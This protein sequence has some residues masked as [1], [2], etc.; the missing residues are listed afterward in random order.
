M[1][2][3]VLTISRDVKWSGSDFRHEGVDAAFGHRIVRGSK[4]LHWDG[5]QALFV[6]CDQ[7]DTCVAAVAVRPF[8]S[9]ARPY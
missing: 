6:L 2:P 3:P 1:G 5:A 7:V 8:A 9:T 4:N